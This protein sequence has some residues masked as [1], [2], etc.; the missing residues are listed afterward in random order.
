MAPSTIF[1]S[2]SI[3]FLDLTAEGQINPPRIALF[4][5]LVL[6]MRL[7]E[8]LLTGNKKQRRPNSILS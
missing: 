3:F 5:L 7:E 8:L 2:F 4:S 1:K 6:A